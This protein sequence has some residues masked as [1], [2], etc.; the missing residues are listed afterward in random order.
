[1]TR[2]ALVGWPVAAALAAI[3]IVA[4]G[5]VDPEPAREPMLRWLGPGAQL[6]RDVQWIRFQRALLDG[7]REAAIRLA[8]SAVELDPRSTAGWKRLAAHLALYRGS[9]EREPDIDR[10]RAW[11]HAGLATARSGAERAVD[12]AQ[13]HAWRGLLC[14]SRAELDPELDPGGAAALF[15]TAADAF[16]EAARCGDAGAAELASYARERAAE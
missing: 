2:T 14:V 6:A 12:P 1:M 13:L 10:R 9:P 7:R 8:A 4:S 16:D 5:P 15:A 11:F 3:S